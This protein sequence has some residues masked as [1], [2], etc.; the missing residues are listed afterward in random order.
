MRTDKMNM[1]ALMIQKNFRRYSQRRWYLGL[2]KKI[3]ELQA[4][5]R[6]N[7]AKKRKQHLVQIESA[8]KIQR[9]FRQH[10]VRKKFLKIVRG[11]VKLQKAVK[12]RL[13]MKKYQDEKMLSAVITIQRRWKTYKARKHFKALRRAVV[14]FQARWRGKLARRRYAE[15]KIEARAVAAVLTQKKELEHKLDSLEMKLVAE[16]RQFNRLK[17]SNRNLEGEHQQLSAKLKD[18]E[19][20]T[21]KSISKLEKENERLS[22]ENQAFKTK[23]EKEN[24]TLKV[25]LRDDTKA[26]NKLKMEMTEEIRALK[27]QLEEQTRLREEERLIAESRQSQLETVNDMLKAELEQ[28][29]KEKHELE[30]Q[31]KRATA[32]VEPTEFEV[33]SSLP[34]PPP[35][36]SSSFFLSTY[37]ICPF[38]I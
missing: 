3:I 22:N 14:K 11:I 37:T 29:L 13:V 16:S 6:V 33:L 8:K 27:E 15:L 12:H 38:F 36:F 10:L 7:I 26:W 32:K 9:K 1:S 23:Y 18:L 25:Q 2:R 31:L 17:E 21:T 30:K 35:I 19:G 24:E 5:C 34:L 20:K 4:V 28:E